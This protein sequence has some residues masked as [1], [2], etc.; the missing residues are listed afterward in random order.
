MARPE[1][2]KITET[3]TFKD[4]LQALRN[5]PAFFKLVWQTNPLM[6]MISLGAAYCKVGNAG[7]TYYT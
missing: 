5:L 6:L 2:N 3:L 7:Y 1:V 4:R